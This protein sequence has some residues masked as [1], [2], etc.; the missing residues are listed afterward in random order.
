MP[1]S[2]MANR[3]A[4]LKITDAGGTSRDMTPYWLSGAPEPSVEMIDVTSVA[5]AGK[6]VANGLKDA[7]L[8]VQLLHDGSGTLTPWPVLAGLLNTPGSAQNVLYYPSG[9]AGGNPIVTIPCR[10]ASLRPSGNVGD[11]VV[12]DAEFALDGTWIIGT[13]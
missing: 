10:L 4:E 6:R 11:K 2:I 12:L 1:F 5:D 9:T 7:S 13:V 8:S 3:G